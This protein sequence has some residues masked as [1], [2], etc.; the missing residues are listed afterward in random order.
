MRAFIFS[1]RRSGAAVRRRELK[2]HKDFIEVLEQTAKSPYARMEAG[3]VRPVH[4]GLTVRH[5]TAIGSVQ[6][7]P[8]SGPPAGHPG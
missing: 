1:V 8:A 7:A 3:R 6:R 4:V 5:G 2:S